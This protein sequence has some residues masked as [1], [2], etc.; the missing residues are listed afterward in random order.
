M[1]HLLVMAVIIQYKGQQILKILLLFELK[2]VHTEFI[3]KIS[4]HKAKKIMFNLVGK[5]GN[6]YCNN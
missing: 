4:K 2:K 3:L 1:I 5:T 6:N